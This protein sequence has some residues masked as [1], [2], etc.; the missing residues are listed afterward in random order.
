M[1]GETE[2]IQ[3]MSG[4]IV[5]VSTSV[6]D[7]YYSSFTENK[8]FYFSNIINSGLYFP[9]IMQFLCVIIYICNGHVSF[10]DVFLCNLVSG[11][12]F[13]FAWYFLR[14]HKYI[15]GV[16]F[17][18]CLIGGNIFRFKLHFLAIAAVSLFIMKNW[19]IIMYCLIGGV[20][21][22]IVRSLLVGALSNVKYNDA[23]VIFA[24]KARY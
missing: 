6:Y 2:N 7:N 21:T 24:A 5:R 18:S 23:A 10:G 20:V 16:C 19:L 11:V 12:A 8:S 1:S 15:P 3:L 22:G 9:Q 4:R 17:L 13:T 14:L